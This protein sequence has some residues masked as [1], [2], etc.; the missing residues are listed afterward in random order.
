MVNI[1]ALHSLITSSVGVNRAWS[2]TT[3]SHAPMTHLDDF[4]HQ[5]ES[6]VPLA[7]NKVEYPAAPPP[8]QKNKMGN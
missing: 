3:H 7:Y 5:Q 8:H 6:S 2:C 4:I 1:V